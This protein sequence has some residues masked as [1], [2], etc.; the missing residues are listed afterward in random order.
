L[1]LRVFSQP[2]LRLLKIF[3]KITTANYEEEKS[4]SISITHIKYK[5]KIFFALA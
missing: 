2:F 4:I 5:V 3:K 1:T